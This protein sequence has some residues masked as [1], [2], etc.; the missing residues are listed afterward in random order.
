MRCVQQ[1]CNNSGCLNIVTSSNI[2]NEKKLEHEKLKCR[3]WVFRRWQCLFSIYSRDLITFAEWVRTKTTKCKNN[4]ND[5]EE[6]EKKLSPQNEGER[7]RGNA[8]KKWN[9]KIYRSTLC[10]T[11]KKIS[12]RNSNS[13]KTISHRHFC[14]THTNTHIR[15][16]TEVEGGGAT[17][18]TSVY[19]MFH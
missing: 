4:I 1:L 11:I 6:R 5:S 19:T 10:E 17:Q 12:C 2:P 3:R 18:H 14:P 15:G 16:K 9:M 8:K 13:P 7:D